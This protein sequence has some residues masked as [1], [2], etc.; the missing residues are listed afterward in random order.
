MDSTI[1]LDK[2]DSTINLDK[3]ENKNQIDFDNFSTLQ[4][5]LFNNN[6]KDK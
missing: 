3:Y 1:N 2:L 6:C 4:D 5:P